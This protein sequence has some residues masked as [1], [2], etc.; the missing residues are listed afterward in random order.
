MKTPTIAESFATY[1]AG[2]IPRGASD[3]Q[4]EE[5]R[6]AF[7]AGSYFLLMHALYNLG[8]DSTSEDEGAEQLEAI[9]VECEA[10]AKSV[11]MPLP[12][13]EPP[14]PTVPDHHYTTSDADEIKPLLR[15]LADHIREELPQGWGFTLLIF[16]FDPGSLFYIANAERADVLVMMRKFIASQT[17]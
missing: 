14:A 16:E 4:V 7:Y 15:A 8:D 5:C 6:R 10:F 3:V 1:R 13:A 11:G 12:I 9:R 2:V 17:Q